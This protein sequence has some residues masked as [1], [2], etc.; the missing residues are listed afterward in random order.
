MPRPFPHGIVSVSLAFAAFLLG[1]AAILAHSPVAGLL[2]AGLVVASPL[3]IAF[4]FCVRCPCRFGGCGH[5]L[6]GL[7]ARRLPSRIGERHGRLELLA[8]SAVVAALVLGPQAWLWRNPAL[9]APFWALLAVAAVEIRRY[10]CPGCGFEAC[11][12]KRARAAK[13]AP[14]PR[15]TGRGGSASCE[16][17][18][19]VS[20]RR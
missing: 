11:P 16:A 2:Y 13:E 18:K 19:G 15:T 12:A 8:L 1:A 3:L 14:S 9:L 6:P 5:V 7:I 17:M 10:V 4:A 20:D